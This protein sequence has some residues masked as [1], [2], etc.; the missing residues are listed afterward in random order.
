MKWSW[1]L[2]SPFEIDVHVHA[3]FLLLLA[4]VGF[5]AYRDTHSPLA[6]L[7]SVLFV[8]AL[9]CLVVMHEYG[10]ALTARQFGI[11]TQR[12][13]LYPIG[14]VAMLQSMP[15]KPREQLLIALAGPAVNFVLAGLIAAG[16]VLTGTPLL[17]LRALTDQPAAIASG[18][19]WANIVMGSFNLFPALPMDGGRVL[20]ALL[21]MRIDPLRAT[22]IAAGVARL[23]ALLMFG[24][25]M[26]SGT[27]MLAVI[28]VVVWIGANAE[29]RMATNNASSMPLP[30]RDGAYNTVVENA[31]PPDVASWPPFQRFVGAPRARGQ[32]A[33]K[34]V[35]EIVQGPDGPRLRYRIR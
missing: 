22:L 8:S 1:K 32:A 10:H 31:A 7:V 19:F 16:L 25:A 20:R 3:S 12:I 11:R 34:A 2:G 4:W 6:V 18:L 27:A 5:G 26:Y 23:L 33:F 28:A 21:A 9:F 14:G 15:T 35:V 17:S 30:P 13:T 24:Y 29:R